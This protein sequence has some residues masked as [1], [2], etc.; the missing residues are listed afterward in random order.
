V[1]VFIIIYNVAR[2]NSLPLHEMPIEVR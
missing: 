2:Q 1:E